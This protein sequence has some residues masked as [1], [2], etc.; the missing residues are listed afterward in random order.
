[1]RAK[2]YTVCFN[3]PSGRNISFTWPPM[4]YEQLICDNCAGN[5]CHIRVGGIGIMV[6]FLWIKVMWRSDSHAH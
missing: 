1:M 3:R 4:F 5:T 6:G 2:K